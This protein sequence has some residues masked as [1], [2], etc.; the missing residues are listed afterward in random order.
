[1]ATRLQLRA[2]EL[3]QALLRGFGFLA[4]VV[5]AYVALHRAGLWYPL[6]VADYG[7]VALSC[8]VSLALWRRFPAVHLVGVCVLIGNPW[9]FFTV[10]EIRAIP[11]V[12]AGFL[13]AYAGLRAAV[14]LPLVV[15]AALSSE[16]PGWQRLL[17]HPGMWGEYVLQTGLSLPV[18]ISG[19]GA[20]A[21]LVGRAASLQRRSAESLRAQNEELARLRESDRERIASEERTAIAR[22]V[23]DVV[24]HHLAAIV[25]RAQAAARVADRS[26]AEPRAAVEW[27][28]DAGPQA[29]AEMRSLVRVLRGSAAEGAQ[30]P[31]TLADAIDAV[32][33]RVRSAGIDVR[34]A[35]E[36]PAG[37]SAVQ[38]F[39]VLRVCQ[40]ALTN[41]LVHSRATAVDV[42]LSAADG[43]TVLTVED[44]GAQA[45][46]AAEPGAPRAATDGGSG[47]PGMRERAKA[48]GGAV[49]AGWS[50][51]GW[52]VQLVVP[53]AAAS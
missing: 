37:L 11:L 41:V 15:L 36:V 6:A 53:G 1:V 30:S 42:Q 3:A 18:L 45:D 21:V 29:L 35:V 33:A 48:V 44:D 4:V 24:A 43:D 20:A 47:I 25:V 31:A 28:A 38:E 9:W 49:T 39:A 50:S 32:V 26:P 5:V 23:H 16:F 10:G 51:R 46:A 2:L 34:T 17:P 13:A 12:F 8:A 14:A 7:W 27:I 19:L 22:E 40:E 52:R